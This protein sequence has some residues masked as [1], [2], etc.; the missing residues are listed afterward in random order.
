MHPVEPE[1]FHCNICKQPFRTKKA[2]KRH[3]KNSHKN[4]PTMFQKKESRNDIGNIDGS[5]NDLR[6]LKTVGKVDSTSKELKKLSKN[7]KTSKKEVKD[8][9]DKQI[10]SKGK[11]LSKVKSVAKNRDKSLNSKVKPNKVMKASKLLVKNKLQ[12]CSTKMKKQIERMKNL[13]KSSGVK[14]I[15]MNKLIKVKLASGKLAHNKNQIDL[16]NSKSR[17]NGRNK[18]PDKTKKEMNKKSIALKPTSPINKTQLIKKPISPKVASTADVQPSPPMPFACNFCGMRFRNVSNLNRHI[19]FHSMTKYHCH[20]CSDVFLS[21]RSLTKHLLLHKDDPVVNDVMIRCKICSESF[22]NDEL[23]KNHCLT[24][25][26]SARIETERGA[27]RKAG[28]RKTERVVESVS[29]AGIIT[30]DNVFEADLYTSDKLAETDLRTSETGLRAIKLIPLTGLTGSEKTSESVLQT[31]ERVSDLRTSGKTIVTGLTNLQNINCRSCKVQFDNFKAFKHHV[32]VKHI[33]LGDTSLQCDKC[34]DVFTSESVVISHLVKQHGLSSREARGIMRQKETDAVFLGINAS[35]KDNQRLVE[36]AV[37]ADK[38]KLFAEKKRAPF[39]EKSPKAQRGGLKPSSKHN[40]VTAQQKANKTLLSSSV[41]DIAQ[42]TKG[43][44]SSQNFQHN[45]LKSSTSCES[46]RIE[47]KTNYIKCS[48][49]PEN[50]SKFANIPK[51]S[52]NSTDNDLK[53]S[54]GRGCLR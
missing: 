25:V 7:D 41:R 23:L 9:K 47:D 19:P 22:E 6:I 40:Q 1:G 11:D 33:D 8:K 21:M 26:I 14:N 54:I 32:Q 27:K 45:D 35:M 28:S 5:S 29:N 30:N 24:H 43:K 3:Q 12:P 15:K 10:T 2:L 34:G 42:L 51:A 44:P 39:V 16:A 17:K 20:R 18:L 49:D 37:A 48:T 38:G 36:N 53:S 13:Q 52:L 31:N 50:R 4:K 46:A